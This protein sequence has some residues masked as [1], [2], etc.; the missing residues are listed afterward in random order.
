[1]RSD[2]NVIVV[3]KVVSGRVSLAGNVLFNLD[4]QYP[5][6]IFSIFIKKEE[7]VNFDY[8]SVSF[9]KRKRIAVTGKVDDLGDKTV[10]YIGKGKDVEVLK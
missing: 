8:D 5:H 1:M 7:L 10:M 3:G 6:E 9:L 2:V 4:K